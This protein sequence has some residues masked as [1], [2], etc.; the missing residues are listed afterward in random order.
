MCL[1][2]TLLA[3]L[4]WSPLRRFVE[5][6]A[7]RLQPR[8]PRIISGPLRGYLYA[9][10]LAQWLGIYEFEVQGI[11]A[12][13]VRPGNVV[14]DIGANNGFISMLAAQLVSEDGFVYAFEPLPAN[15]SILH[16]LFSANDV[17]NCEVV[18]LAVADVTAELA[19]F[20]GS[21]HTTSSLHSGRGNSG[22][23]TV[24]SITL[25]AFLAA[26]QPPDFIKID[27]EGAE[28]E[29]LKGSESL[30]RREPAPVWLIEV[31]SAESERQT[32][33]ELQKYGYEIHPILS[34]RERPDAFPRHILTLKCP[35]V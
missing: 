22:S 7:R 33:S 3:W 17:I 10:G 30:L 23:V 34:R 8:I 35:N 6:I 21:S 18:P 2:N 32:I 4:W 14:Y 27:V 28:S 15:V 13:N 16:N 31:H 1:L 11:M 24:S 20:V 12:E 9:G 25:D 5:A 19:L 26:H 29:V